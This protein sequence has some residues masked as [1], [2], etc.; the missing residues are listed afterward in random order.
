MTLI[1]RLR[2]SA[3]RLFPISLIAFIMAVSFTTA[4]YGGFPRR[5]PLGP[6][7]EGPQYPSDYDFEAMSYIKEDLGL[8]TIPPN[9]LIL[10][11][12]HTAIAATLEFGHMKLIKD[13]RRFPIVSIYQEPELD[14]AWRQVLTNP[15]LDP[16]DY[17]MELTG[18]DTVYIVLTYRLAMG[19]ENSLEGLVGTFTTFLGQPIFQ[20]DGK[21]YVFKYR[22]FEPFNPRFILK[23]HHEDS[24]QVTKVNPDRTGSV[25]DINVA[26]ID[27]MLKIGITEGKF[28]NFHLRHIYEEFQDWSDKNLFIMELKGSGSGSKIN[29]VVRTSP[30]DYFRFIIE[31]DRKV[32]RLIIVPFSSFE[33]IGSP[34][35]SRVTELMLNIM[36]YPAESPFEIFIGTIMIDARGE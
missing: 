9:F 34:S 15:S 3:M 2:K 4:L 5:W 22:G 35:W 12:H 23:E 10:G 26:L 27:G 6:Y 31:D 20:I 21:V 29:V 25:Y 33:I 17:A 18:A 8:I 1:L 16:L 32:L 36:P 28:L 7:S 14:V 11:D 19:S 13:G 24:W 30:F